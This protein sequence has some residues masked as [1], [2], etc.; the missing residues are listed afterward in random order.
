MY[1]ISICDKTQGTSQDMNKTLYR[2]HGTYLP[3]APHASSS[4]GCLRFPEQVKRYIYIDDVEQR[5]DAVRTFE[6]ST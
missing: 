2:V 5:S 1:R 4:C 6:K 3:S